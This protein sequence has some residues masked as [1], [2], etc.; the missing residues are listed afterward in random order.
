MQDRPPD[1]RQ[2]TELE[3]IIMA[4]IDWE[5]VN[6]GVARENEKMIWRPYGLPT[7]LDLENSAFHDAPIST[8]WDIPEK[9][10]VSVAITGA[11]FQHSQNPNQPIAPQEILDSAREVAREGAKYR[12]HPCP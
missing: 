2:I 7:V 6:K 12:A 10:A 1:P 8:P 9:L 5:R 3:G 11:F 4:N